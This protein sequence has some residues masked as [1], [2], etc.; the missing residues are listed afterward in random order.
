MHISL[1]STEDEETTADNQF[2]LETKKG[3]NIGIR[4]LVF[5]MIN[6]IFLKNL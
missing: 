6:L 5:Q 1:M 4:L 2:N 3:R